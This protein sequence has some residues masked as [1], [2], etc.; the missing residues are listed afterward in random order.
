MKLGK[1]KA[2]TLSAVLK[3]S[4]IPL[5]ILGRNP[6]K[7]YVPTQG[8]SPLYS[9]R[10]AGLHPECRTIAEIRQARDHQ[11]QR[12]TARRV[13][14]Q[15]NLSTADSR[16]SEPGPDAVS[17][18][19]QANSQAANGGSPLAPGSSDRDKEVDPTQDWEE[20][21]SHIDTD[22]SMKTMDR[23]WNASFYH[24][25]RDENNAD[26]IARHLAPLLK[27]YKLGQ[28]SCGLSWL[29]KGWKIE[30]VSRL[31]RTVFADWLP[32]LAG[33]VFAHISKGWTL[34]PQL[35]LCVAFLLIN[36][37]A[38]V[39]ALFTRSLTSKWS[40]EA[41]L[42][43]IGY[44]DSVLEWEEEYFAEFTGH[45]VC[46]MKDGEE[47]VSLVDIENMYRNNLGGLNYK[48][49]VSDYHLAVAELNISIVTH[50][51]VCARCQAHQPCPTLSRVL[52]GR[53]LEASPAPSQPEA[54]VE[55][56]I[57]PSTTHG[58][59]MAEASIS[60]ASLPISSDALSESKSSI[61]LDADFEEGA[62]SCPDSDY[63]SETLSYE[64]ELQVAGAG[65]TGDGAR[66]LLSP[67][68]RTSSKR[69]LSRSGSSIFSLSDGGVA[70][71]NHI[72]HQIIEDCSEEPNAIDGETGYNE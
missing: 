45:F 30:S 3:N 28:V 40:K 4:D 69:T 50:F 51:L 19:K 18:I 13:Y 26:C 59:A 20:S 12:E 35:G 7:N 17:D 10:T 1:L 29:I 5:E 24:F 48:L 62:E 32:D 56:D 63:V 53:Y 44:L 66:R 14:G 47:S 34:R 2:S 54:A 46:S 33:I 15:G 58:A 49:V 72:I 16:S 25:V 68:D 70:A 21:I 65:S 8:D 42:Q 31:L 43:L 64:G 37:P 67:R 9:A 52:A 71:L 27:D 6:W 36:E 55:S 11:R 38:S 61:D 22:W 41:A 23:L 39:A 60:S 57:S